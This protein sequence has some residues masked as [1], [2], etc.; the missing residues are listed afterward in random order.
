MLQLVKKMRAVLRVEHNKGKIDPQGFAQEERRLELM[1]LKINISN[2]VKRAMDARIQG[3]YGTCRQLYTKGLSAMA[4]VG[5]KDPYLLAREEDMR[6]GLK[7]LEELQ[8]QNSAQDLQ[9]IKD[10]EA[11]EL[12]VLFQ[13]KKKW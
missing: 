7:E 10:K 2:L 12:D 5:D 4:S 8:Q 3:Q 13:P 9:N 6:Q 1:Q 11:D